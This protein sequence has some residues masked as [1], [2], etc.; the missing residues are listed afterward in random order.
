MIVFDT[1]TEFDKDLKRPLKKYGSL[2]SDLEIVKIILK[3]KPDERLPFSFE[4][5]NLGIETCAIKVKK[6]ACDSLKGKGVNSG[7]ILIY[8]PFPDEGKIIFIELYHKNEKEIEDRERIIL[9]FK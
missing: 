6:I 4:I 2:V 5:N 7:L 8:A 3:V 9:N 1:L